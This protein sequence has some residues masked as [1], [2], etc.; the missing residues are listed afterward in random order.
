[1]RSGDDGYINVPE[2]EIMMTLEGHTSYVNCMIQLT[3][4]RL[5]SG[6]D[7]NTLKI[8]D[9]ISGSC[10]M[11]LEGHTN[12]VFCVTQLTY[13][14]LVSS[15]IDNTLRIWDTISGSCLMTLEGHNY[16]RFSVKENT[17]R[18]RKIKNTK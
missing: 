10:L 15:S 2:G 7:D 13:G 18:R 14:R 9:T 1:M 6:S 5:V 8:W 3:D 4:G 17:K 11:T 16:C 12:S